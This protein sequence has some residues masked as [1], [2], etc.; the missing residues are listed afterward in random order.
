[1]D[2]FREL[3]KQFDLD[4]LPN[5]DGK[6]SVSLLPVGY[7]IKLYGRN[8]ILTD[9]KNPTIEMGGQVYDEYELFGATSE[10]HEC[11]NLKRP[12]KSFDDV[13]RELSDKVDD[14][15]KLMSNDFQEN[16]S[17]NDWVLLQRI[18]DLLY[19]RGYEGRD[20][21]ELM[22]HIESSHTILKGHER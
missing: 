16:M 20:S 8:Y 14:Q 22:E 21:H 4:R 19:S 6:I 15:R 10:H 11:K 2:Q 18:A 1:M 9:E 5:R 12:K 7:P 13:F 17:S 3:S